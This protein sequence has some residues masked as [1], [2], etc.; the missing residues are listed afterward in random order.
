[1]YYG[2]YNRWGRNSQ[3][4]GVSCPNMSM[5]SLHLEVEFEAVE[6]NINSITAGRGQ[7]SDYLQTIYKY[8]KEL[9]KGYVIM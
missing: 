7:Y 4:K 6:D 2:N 1:M 3:N 5:K 8:I 9:L